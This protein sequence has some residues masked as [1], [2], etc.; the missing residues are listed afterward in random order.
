MSCTVGESNLHPLLVCV[1][2]LSKLPSEYQAY[3]GVKFIWAIYAG[4]MKS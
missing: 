1:L 4:N 3:D 2:E